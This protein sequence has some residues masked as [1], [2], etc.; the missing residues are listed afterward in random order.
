MIS[1]KA[2]LNFPLRPDLSTFWRVDDAG[3]CKE[4]DRCEEGGGCEVCDML[5]VNVLLTCNAVLFLD[6]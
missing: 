5:D 3:V 4:D 2:L 1:S 6:V